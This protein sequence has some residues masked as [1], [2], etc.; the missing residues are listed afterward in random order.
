MSQNAP[1]GLQIVGGCTPHT[2]TVNSF[3]LTEIKVVG[4]GPTGNPGWVGM[5]GWVQ[6]KT[7]AGTYHFMTTNPSAP[8][9]DPT[10]GTA[11]VPIV[12]CSFIENTCTTQS[13]IA[14][15]GTGSGA[16]TGSYNLTF[17]VGQQFYYLTAGPFTGT[18]TDWSSMPL[19]DCIVP[20]PCIGGGQQV[21]TPIG[22]RAI[23]DLV[24]G[25]LILTHD[26]RHVPVTISQFFCP[27]ITD[28]NCPILIP[29]NTFGP[30]SPPQDLI[31]SPTHYFMVKPGVWDVPNRLINYYPNITQIT[32]YMGQQYLYYSISTPNYLTDNV[33][34]NGTT[35][36]SYGQNFTEQYP[37]DREY[38]FFDEAINGCTRITLP[39]FLASLKH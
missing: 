18:A 23:E 2:I 11:T 5:Q 17:A 24:T 32:S 19:S 10:S 28:C 38:Y 7:N 4:I 34:V 22:Y 13:I 29:A 31:L 26:N 1:L 20:I 21:L 14:V 3:P 30:M 36:E 9:F 33:V 37:G 6:F 39:T 12:H 8:G 15:I 25:D 35:I 27:I 16:V